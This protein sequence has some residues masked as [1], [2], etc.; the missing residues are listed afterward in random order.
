VKPTEKLGEAV[1]PDG[2]VLA[3]Y[4]HDGAYTIRAGGVELMSTRRHA[5]E[6]R[7]AALA[8]APLR[9][10][11]GARVLVGGLGLGFTLRA[12]L[13]ALAADARVVVAELVPAVVAWNREPSYGL[14]ADALADPRT[15]L[16][17]ADVADVLR[18]EPGAFDAVLLDVDNG[19]EALTTAGN[20]GLYGR[21]GIRL[22]A[23][24]LRRGGRLAYWAADDARDFAAALRGASL[25]VEGERVRAYGGGGP[26]HTILVARVP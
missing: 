12:A 17:L 16:R 20:A 11:P 13:D 9:D 2:T 1:A 25:V 18:A 5:S 3:L 8:C 19:A 21:A 24:A 22:A 10:V 23:A 15:E 7:L 26:W 14:G 4:R 6:E